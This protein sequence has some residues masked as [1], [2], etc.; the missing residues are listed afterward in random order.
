MKLFTGSD[1]NTFPKDFLCFHSQP[2]DQPNIWA[3]FSLV[4]EWNITS[5]SQKCSL[6]P[7][8]HSEW[9][10]SSTCMEI[11]KICWTNGFE[12]RSTFK[13]QETRVIAPG[14]GRMNSSPSLLV[15]QA[16][17]KALQR[18]RV[19]C[20]SPC[21]AKSHIPTTFAWIT[22]SKGI[23]QQILLLC[24]IQQEGIGRSMAKPVHSCSTGFT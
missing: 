13:G 4:W 3:N 10:A 7:S 8:L 19:Q 16:F 1:G 2:T 12:G 17:I 18:E 9:A 24:F 15:V 21:Q 11:Y 23:I 22:R 6:G 14:N 20:F 5:W